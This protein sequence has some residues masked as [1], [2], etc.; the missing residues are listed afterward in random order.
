MGKL[1]IVIKTGIETENKMKS[2]Y[3][4]VEDNHYTM[5]SYSIIYART[6][7]IIDYWLNRADS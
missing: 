6:T 3:S 5:H 4:L 7:V 2:A 1:R